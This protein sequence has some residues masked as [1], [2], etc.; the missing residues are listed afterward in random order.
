MAESGSSH[1]N[2]PIF[3]Y[4]KVLHKDK[5]VEYRTQHWAGSAVLHV[6]RTWLETKFQV[7]FRTRCHMWLTDV[8]KICP[9]C[10]HF[11]SA[12]TCTWSVACAKPPANQWRG[13]RCVHVEVEPPFQ[14]AK[15]RCPKQLRPVMSFQPAVV[16]QPPQALHPAPPAMPPPQ[17]QLQTQHEAQHQFISG[18]A[19][20]QQSTNANMKSLSSEHKQAIK[21][22]C[23]ADNLSFV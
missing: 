8:H 18:A 19:G 11:G 7:R 5:T 3:M 6:C 12:C 13:A 23:N 16:Q 4:S 17:A 15:I 9:D 20:H 14:E 2:H 10:K 1:Q 21:H 22:S